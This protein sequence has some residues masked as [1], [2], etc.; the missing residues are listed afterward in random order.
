MRDTRFPALVYDKQH[1]FEIQNSVNR[2]PVK[3]LVLLAVD[4][5]RSRVAA[6]FGQFRKRNCPSLRFP[7]AKILA[8]KK[9]LWLRLCRAVPLCG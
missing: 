2:T 9:I 3:F 1:D 5:H 4:T 6:P 8:A 7:N